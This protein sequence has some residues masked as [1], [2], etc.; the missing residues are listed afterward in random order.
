MHSSLSQAFA[1]TARIY[2]KQ[3]EALASTK[4][5]EVAHPALLLAKPEALAATVLARLLNLLAKPEPSPEELAA[6][7]G[8]TR[9]TRVASPP[10]GDGEQA[11]TAPAPVLVL[12]AR[13]SLDENHL[14]AILAARRL[15]RAAEAQILFDALAPSK[16]LYGGLGLPQKKDA[17]RTRA[18]EAAVDKGDG[19]G[20]LI[21]DGWLPRWS[22]FQDILAKVPAKGNPQQLAWPVPV[23]ESPDGSV[24]AVQLA[25]FLH[26]CL[27][28]LTEGSVLKLLHCYKSAMLGDGSIDHLARTATPVQERRYPISP[29]SRPGMKAGPRQLASRLVSG[30][31]AAAAEAPVDVTALDP[32]AHLALPLPAA[33]RV[34][35]GLLACHGE[36]LARE[37]AR[38]AV[39]AYL[40]RLAGLAAEF[41]GGSAAAAAPP[42]LGRVPQQE[43]RRLLLLASKPRA[44]DPIRILR[45]TRRYLG[46]AAGGL[47]ID[48]AAR[49]GDQLLSLALEAAEDGGRPAF[50]RAEVLYPHG[51]ALIPRDIVAL[52]ADVYERLW[53]PRLSEL[54]LSPWAVPTHPMVERPRALE[55]ALTGAFHTLPAQVMKAH[56]S[57]QMQLLREAEE[58]ARG[59]LELLTL[60]EQQQQ[61]QQQ[62]QQEEPAAPAAPAPSSRWAGPSAAARMEGLAVPRTPATV[63][64]ALD[65]LGGQGW[66]VNPNIYPLL[67]RIWEEPGLAP[68]HTGLG[69][70]RKA[71]LT[72]PEL[73]APDRRF[74]VNFARGPFGG[75]SIEAGGKLPYNEYR[76]FRAAR[77]AQLKERREVYALSCEI[78][79]KLRAA[80]R[81]FSESAFYL[82]H[83]LD[84][85][86]RAYPYHP[87]LSTMGA[88]YS[89][90]L[91]QFAEG[92]PLGPRGW[93]WLLIHAANTYASGGVDKLSLD[94]KSSPV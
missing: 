43:A 29:T 30:G 88:D 18:A 37:P 1:S 45:Y 24:A 75:S 83:F 54:S 92:R 5:A 93:R 3:L 47:D 62:Q 4:P 46:P 8:R 90:A 20:P 14:L 61:Q 26:R 44:T 67:R 50:L 13:T 69:L 74:Q 52:R 35:S 64:R 15:G 77:Q 31:N 91:L 23:A 17:G 12:S 2:A 79:L 85:R 49:L 38:E 53:A 82:P 73:S 65:A 16:A 87:Y 42:A 7:G 81:V 66:S 84:F 58:A 89:R 68:L 60:P 34:L 78:D 36:V 48:S 63:Y 22:S 19:T 40:E 6:R 59:A 86:G 55:S 94:G 80:E 25:P 70:P 11:A 57:D 76:E 21:S 28:F 41:L 39:V 10:S 71:A 72:E 27:P 32:V 33:A 9:R 56:D 51:Q